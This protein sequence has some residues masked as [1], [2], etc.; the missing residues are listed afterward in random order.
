MRTTENFKELGMKV[1]EPTFQKYYRAG[2]LENTDEEF[3]TNT[4]KPYWNSY[5]HEE[6]ET[7]IHA[8]FHSVAGFKDHRVVPQ[9]VMWDIVMPFLNDMSMTGAY[10]DKNLYDI[11]F[12]A[13][14]SPQTY[15]KRI[16]YKFYDGKN[17][18]LTK[19]EAETVVTNLEEAIIKPSNRDNG[20]GIQKIK[21]VD[22]AVQMGEET[23]GFNDLIDLAGPNFIV[24]EVIRQHPVMAAPHPHSV[25]TLRMVTLRWNNEIHYCLTF[26]RF[27]SNGAVQDN[28]G[29]GGVCVGITDEGYFVKQAV[30]EHANV[31]EKHPTTGFDFKNTSSRIPDFEKYIAFVKKLHQ[32]VLHH[33]YVSWDIAVGEDG[34]P[35]F[36]EANFRGAA[37]LYQLASQRPVLGSLTTEIFDEINRLERAEE[38]DLLKVSPADAAKKKKIRTLRR[39]VRRLKRETEQGKAEKEQEKAEKETLTSENERMNKK[40][41]RQRRKI[42]RMQREAEEQLKWK[43]DL[44]NSSYWKATL[45]LRKVLLHQRKE[46]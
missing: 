13:E 15:I 21:I 9:Y 35:I 20:N 39:R 25:N 29:A 45:P 37:W 4:V 43:E 23:I 27:G 5:L 32:K 28:A 11:L 41:K 38:I 8:A 19:K 31:M 40:V 44:T 12:Q 10:S 16:D 7:S 22:S 30:D 14:K 26:A 24:Q 1:E 6:V 17:K 36:L 42:K 3:L 2:L 18:P 34:E 33:H 46:E